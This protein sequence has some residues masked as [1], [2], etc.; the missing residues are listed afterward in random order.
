MSNLITFDASALAT[1][2]LEITSSMT[3][4][5]KVLDETKQQLS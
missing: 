2:V 1:K 5:R 4:L 3:H